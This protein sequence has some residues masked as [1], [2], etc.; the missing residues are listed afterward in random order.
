MLIKSEYELERDGCTIYAVKHE[1]GKDNRISIYP[2]DERFE[3]FIFKKS[4]PETLKAIGKL[5][6]EAADL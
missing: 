5:L 3:T 1:C 6:I 4:S 2:A